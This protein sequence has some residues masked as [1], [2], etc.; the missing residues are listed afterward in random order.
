MAATNVKI[1]EPR[2]DALPAGGTRAGN[3]ENGEVGRR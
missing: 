3:P 2:F 1:G